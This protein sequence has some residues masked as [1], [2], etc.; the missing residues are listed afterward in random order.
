MRRKKHGWILWLLA[1][2]GLGCVIW[3]ASRMLLAP[4]SLPTQTKTLEFYQQ[5]EEA[6]AAFVS[7]IEAYDARTAEIQ[8]INIPA[9]QELLVARIQNGDTPDIFTDWPTQRSFA[10]IVNQGLVADLSDLPMLASV[11]ERALSMA[12]QPNGHVYA[13]PLNYNCMEVYYNRSLFEQLGAQPPQTL[14]ELFALCEQFKQAGIVPMVFSIRDHGRTMH[15]AQ[16]LFAILVDDYLGKLERLA[17]DT[18]TPDELDELVQAMRIMRRLYEQS[19]AL[20]DAAYT[21]YEACQHFANGEAA[22][23]ISGSYALNTIAS[24]EGTAVLDVF[25]LPGYTAERKVMLSSIDTAVCISSHTEY[26]EDALAFL[27]YLATPETAALYGSLDNAPTC[28][29]GVKQQ[30]PLT[31]KM[32]EHIKTY[33][34]AEWMKSRFPVEVVSRCSEALAVYLLTGNETVFWVDMRNALRNG[35]IIVK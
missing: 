14:D 8:Q 23:F 15:I 30:N 16:L 2:L 4:Q 35:P 26:R 25:P 7:V 32:S 18:I 11:D 24:F 9:A 27:T 22:M 1:T 21:Q 33:D 19:G 5:R 28:I 13:L 6:M 29:R 17:D 20:T 12:R 10:S 31:Q 3:G 34:N